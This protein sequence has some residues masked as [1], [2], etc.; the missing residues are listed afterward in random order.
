MLLDLGPTYQARVIGAFADT[1]LPVSEAFW[2]VRATSSSSS[3]ARSPQFCLGV[4]SGG[5]SA[6]GTESGWLL[7]PLVFCQ[8]CMDAVAFKLGR[9]DVGRG[10]MRV[11]EVKVPILLCAARRRM[12][13]CPLLRF[14]NAG[15]SGPPAQ[16]LRGAPRHAAVPQLR[17]PLRPDGG[18][19]IG[20]ARGDVWSGC[21]RCGGVKLRPG[22][23]STR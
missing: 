11:G 13:E 16:G 15:G 23:L 1:A 22:G 14:R 3:T 21:G 12:H 5:A 19:R 18:R 7:G 8:A 2:M 10:E 17:L 9:A 20:A 4:C 6:R